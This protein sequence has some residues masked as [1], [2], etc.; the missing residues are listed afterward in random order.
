[1]DLHAQRSKEWTKTNEKQMDT[2]IAVTDAIKGARRTHSFVLSLYVPSSLKCKA[3]LCSDFFLSIFRSKSTKNA[4]HFMLWELFIYCVQNELALWM[5]F[6]FV[7]SKNQNYLPIQMLL[8]WMIQEKYA[9]N[10]KSNTRFSTSIR[11]NILRLHWTVWT[12]KYQSAHNSN[13][14]GHVWCTK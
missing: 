10:Q 6:Y 9:W 4:V 13:K 11:I 5:Y 8:I 2:P 7:S 12:V 3:Q 1:M 14:H